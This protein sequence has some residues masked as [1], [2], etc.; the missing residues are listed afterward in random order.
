MEK[1]E[2]LIQQSPW[3]EHFVLRNPR[4]LLQELSWIKLD[5]WNVYVGVSENPLV[6]SYLFTGF[7]DVWNVYLVVS[8]NPLVKSRLQIF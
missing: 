4:I 3:M 2:L 5:V 6:K 8:D 1:A 7:I